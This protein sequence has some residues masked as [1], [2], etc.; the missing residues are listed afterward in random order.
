MSF[1]FYGALC[2]SPVYKKSSPVDC[3]NY[4]PISLVIVLYKVYATMLLNRLQA[5]GAESRLWS[6]QFVFRSCSS[7]EDA[8]YVVRRRVEQAWAPSGGRTLLLAL[9]WREAFDCIDLDRLIFALKRFGLEFACA[10]GELEDVLFAD[11]TLLISRTSE[12]LQEYMAAVTKCGAE[13]G[14]QVH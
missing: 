10:L 6:G 14:L 12:H 4:R 7:T 8:L 11:D 1:K 13:Y 2:E 3:T 5:A 9:D